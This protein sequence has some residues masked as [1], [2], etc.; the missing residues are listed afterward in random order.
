[1]SSAAGLGVWGGAGAIGGCG[2]VNVGVA[3]GC[4]V[5]DWESTTIGETS[6]VAES[7]IGISCEGLIVNVGAT[8]GDGNSNGC[9]D[10]CG[11]IRN[12]VRPGIM[13]LA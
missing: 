5:C 9:W 12:V 11:A 13:L 1:M 7:A 6:C 3:G 10:G 2:N 8:G 4:I